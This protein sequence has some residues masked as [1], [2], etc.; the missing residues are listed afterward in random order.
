MALKTIVKVGSITNLSDARY[1]AG[2]GV[3]MLGFCFSK[4]SEHYIDLEKFEEIVNWVSGVHIVAEFG[5]E[6]KEKTESI[7]SKYDF[8]GI[9]S[10]NLETA[11]YWKSKNKKV[12]YNVD[13]NS[14]ED[15]NSFQSVLSKYSIF[16]FIQIN[17]TNE[18]LVASLEN[19]L[20]SWSQKINVLKSF[21]VSDEGIINDIQKG[22]FKGI[23]LSGSEEEKPGM[24]DYDEIADILEAIEDDE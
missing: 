22:Q 2:M 17:C 5:Q 3:D 24:K 14:D 16:D 6:E 18:T 7:L 8:D 12:I 11:K 10:S 23:S 21:N 9:Q 20:V 19:E 4:D 13:I 15:M 1:C